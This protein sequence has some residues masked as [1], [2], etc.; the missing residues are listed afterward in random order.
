MSTKWAL[1]VVGVLF[2]VWVAVI[3][4][5]WRETARSKDDDGTLP[6]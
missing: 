4:H 6:P 5:A 1:V 2:V 3:L